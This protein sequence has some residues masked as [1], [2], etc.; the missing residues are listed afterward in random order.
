MA[1]SEPFEFA[2]YKRPR[3]DGPT[4][5]TRDRA[6]LIAIDTQPSQ[7]IGLRLPRIGE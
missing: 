4:H 1:T 7:Q 6:A 2:K 5:M 3:F